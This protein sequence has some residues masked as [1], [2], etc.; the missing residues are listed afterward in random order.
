MKLFA[1]FFTAA[2][3]ATNCDSW[4]CPM[5]YDPKCGSDGK[6]YGKLLRENIN[7]IQD[8]LQFQDFPKTW[9]DII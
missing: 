9:H 6:N 3:A 5:N 7:I 8:F 4:I 1:L 2:M